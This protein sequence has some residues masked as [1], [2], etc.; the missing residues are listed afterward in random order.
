MDEKVWRALHI[1]QLVFE[2]LV[3]NK[4]VTPDLDL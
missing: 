2:A 4:F 1:Q 3:I